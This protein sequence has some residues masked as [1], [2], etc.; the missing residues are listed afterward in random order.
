MLAAL[1]TGMPPASPRKRITF[2]AF[3]WAASEAA[4]MAKTRRKRVGF[5]RFGPNSI[6]DRAVRFEAAAFRMPP[7]SCRLPRHSQ[8]ELQRA[9][10]VAR[11]AR[12]QH[13]VRAD[14]VRVAGVVQNVEK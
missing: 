5:I 1:S 7:P 2:R 12:T 9:R 4:Q 3:C 8:A 10:S 13:A 14:A 11:S 6:T